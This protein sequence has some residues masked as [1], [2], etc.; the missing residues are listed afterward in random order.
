MDKDKKKLKNYEQIIENERHKSQKAED[1][2]LKLR[3]EIEFLQKNYNKNLNVIS[4]LK[5][6]IKIIYY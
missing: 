4:K 2:I 5:K 3:K 1:T 6:K